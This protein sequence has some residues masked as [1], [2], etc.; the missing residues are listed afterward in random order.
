MEDPGSN[1]EGR[2]LS[3]NMY[4]IIVWPC[5]YLH[6]WDVT[7]VSYRAAVQTDS[8]ADGNHELD[9]IGLV[10]LPA[11]ALF[12]CY[13]NRQKRRVVRVTS[14]FQLVGGGNEPPLGLR[15]RG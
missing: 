15:L 13:C 3:D 12:Q 5:F 1:P 6:R 8:V 10:C 11:F 7:G 9:K 2:P 14:N 4:L